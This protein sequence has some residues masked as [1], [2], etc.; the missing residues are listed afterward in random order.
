[1][2]VKPNFIT[3]LDSSF[4]DSSYE[5]KTRN[6]FK[7]KPPV[8]PCYHLVSKEH[9]SEFSKNIPHFL[10][11]LQSLVDKCILPSSMRSITRAKHECITRFL[12]FI[13]K[14]YLP[15]VVTKH[16]ELPTEKKNEY[17]HG[18]KY[19]RF[20]VRVNGID[21][22]ATVMAQE[23]TLHNGRWLLNSLGN[24]QLYEHKIKDSWRLKRILKETNSNGILFNYPGVE[25]SSGIPQG[26][27]LVKAYQT[28]LKF[29]EKEVKAKEIIGYGYSIGGGVQGESLKTHTFQPGIKY[30]FIK[31]RSFST[32]DRVVDSCNKLGFL[33]PR[34]G[35]GLN[36]IDSSHRL[37]E[38][39]IPEIVM[40][41]TAK[42]SKTLVSDGIISVDASH[43]K[44]VWI[45]TNSQL[46]NKHFIGLQETH[47]SALSNGSIRKLST[48][49]NQLLS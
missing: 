5:L 26:K 3:F 23:S 19:K 15:E 35:W 1:M 33:L 8:S 9:T 20:T 39:R 41:S 12:P 30:L 31:D 32:L 44:A 16:A 6:E 45:E 2:K 42:D 17:G 27:T 11:P 36:S 4:K 46:S 13:S 43:A 48:I 7:Q 18:W 25:A 10:S 29:L 34:F 40:Q 38:H 37:S 49:V 22:D 21:I 14:K 24:M 47:R 28:M